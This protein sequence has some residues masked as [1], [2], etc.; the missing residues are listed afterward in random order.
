MAH[1]A[2]CCI[3]AVHFDLRFDQTSALLSA[4]LRALL[5]ALLSVMLSDAVKRAIVRNTEKKKKSRKKKRTNENFSMTACVFFA[6]RRKTTWFWPLFLF[7]PSCWSLTFGPNRPLTLL[8][9]G[10]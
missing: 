2:V 8:V 6:P 5:S 1:F 4:V 10:P 7:V 9:F 3:A